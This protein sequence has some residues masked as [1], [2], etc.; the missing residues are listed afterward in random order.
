MLKLAN[1]LATSFTQMFAYIQLNTIDIPA[2]DP[3]I[4]HHGTSTCPKATI[5]SIKGF[6]EGLLGSNNH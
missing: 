5:L 2:F 1:E 4:L 6:R 3:Q